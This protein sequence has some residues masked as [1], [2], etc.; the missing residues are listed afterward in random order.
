MKTKGNWVIKYNN[1][2]YYSGYCSF[3]P[4]LTQANIYSYKE[5]AEDVAKWLNSTTC[6]P[7]KKYEIV[8]I[9]EP[10]ELKDTEAEW[11]VVLHGPEVYACSS[12]HSSALNDYRGRS[13]DSRFCPHCGKRMINSTIEED[14]DV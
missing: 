8:E 7:S 9:S 4:E 1:D 3:R 2:T 5:E 11:A 13:V 14:D 6:A 12:C 10:K